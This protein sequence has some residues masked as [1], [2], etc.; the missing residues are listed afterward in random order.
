MAG[1]VVGEVG[2]RKWQAQYLVKFREIGG[3]RNVVF[4]HT[5]CV[6]Q[7][8]RGSSPKR[9]VRDDEFMVGSWSDPARIVPPLQTAIQEVSLRAMNKTCKLLSIT[10]FQLLPNGSYTPRPMKL[11]IKQKCD[12]RQPGHT[13]KYTTQLLI[14]VVARYHP[15]PVLN[16]FGLACCL[17]ARF[18]RF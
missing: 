13:L 7:M 5:I 4:F 10:S 3:A 11:E 9:R 6:C 1:A 15:L 12:P 16:H 8:G 17:R 2:V 18:P 14:K